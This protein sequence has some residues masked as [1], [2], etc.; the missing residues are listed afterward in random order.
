MNQNQKLTLHGT[1]EMVFRGKFRSRILILCVVALVVLF[2]LDNISTVISDF[3]VDNEHQPL[4]QSPG[5]RE[6]KN[7]VSLI[8][9]THVSLHN[10]V[11]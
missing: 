10:E 3:L 7:H 2:Q 1:L 11:K 4:E 6:T 9:I 8:A 5:K